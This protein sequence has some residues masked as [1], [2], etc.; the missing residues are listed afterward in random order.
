MELVIIACLH[1]MIVWAPWVPVLASPAWRQGCW[2]P[3]HVSLSWARSCKPNL[4]DG[5]VLADAVR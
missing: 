3:L 2:N 1:F 4:P 5:R